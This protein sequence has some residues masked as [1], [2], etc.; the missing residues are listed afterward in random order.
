MLDREVS[1]RV[2]TK[3]YIDL[4]VRSRLSGQI[5]KLGGAERRPMPWGTKY[6]CGD[7]WRTEQSKGV[8]FR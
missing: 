2:P 4:V 3:R 1:V 7:L 6:A 5:S 8:C